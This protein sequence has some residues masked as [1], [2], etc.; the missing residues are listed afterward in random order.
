M[1]TKRL[2]D[3]H[4]EGK[5]NAGLRKQI[6]EA[7]DGVMPACGPV[8]ER[9]VLALGASVALTVHGR[10][11]LAAAAA[12]YRAANGESNDRCDCDSCVAGGLQRLGAL[13]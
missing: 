5:V 2:F 10:A 11:K 6:R 9:A 8:V 13:G 1:T 7:A 3:R 12:D 4:F